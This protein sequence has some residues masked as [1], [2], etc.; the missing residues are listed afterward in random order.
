MH[1]LHVHYALASVQLLHVHDVIFSDT[2]TSMT[3]DIEAK[4]KQT[5]LVTVIGKRR[6]AL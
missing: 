1:L 3:R 5:E 2:Y 6:M 4:G